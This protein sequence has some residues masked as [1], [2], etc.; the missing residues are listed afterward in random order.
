MNVEK[1]TT[2]PTMTEI[3]GPGTVICFHNDTYNSTNNSNDLVFTKNGRVVL[4]SV[5]TDSMSVDV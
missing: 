2:E 4:I 1:Q 5:V 3:V